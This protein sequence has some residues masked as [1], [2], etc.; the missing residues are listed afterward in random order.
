MFEM[1]GVAVRT[2]FAWAATQTGGLVAPHQ[3]LFSADDAAALRR[4][5]FL[6]ALYDEKSPM[7]AR[8]TDIEREWMQIRSDLPLNYKTVI[9]DE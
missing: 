9:S 6:T 3:G 1:I 5:P 2:V 4:G 8:A 7:I